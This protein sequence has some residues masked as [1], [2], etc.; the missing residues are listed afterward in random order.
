MERG[1]VAK[2]DEWREREAVAKRDERREWRRE[3]SG[4]TDTLTV[5]KR[6]RGRD[7]HT[8]SSKE[9]SGQRQTH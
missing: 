1:A 4:E 9:R 2:R 3:I 8:D 6:G 5:A 7:R